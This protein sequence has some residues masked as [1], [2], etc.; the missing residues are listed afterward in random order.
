MESTASTIDVFISRKSADASLAKELYHFLIT[1]GLTVFDSDET[2][3]KMGNTDYLEAIDN[4]LVSCRHMIVVGSS[5]ENITSRW[6]KKEWSSF[7]NEKMSGR[8]NG[9]LL[10]VITSNLTIDNL[11]LS[12]RNNQVI[13]FDNA[14]FDRIAAYVGKDYRDPKY[15]PPRKGILKSKWLLP[16]ISVICLLTLFWYFINERNKPFDATLFLKPS[17]SLKLDPA[18]PPFEGGELTLL[19]DNKAEKKSISAEGEATFKQLP[20]SFRDKKVAASLTASYWTLQ[21]DTIALTKTVNLVLVPDQSLARIFGN[22]KDTKQ[23]GIGNCRITVDNN[24]T[25]FVTDMDGF[26]SITLPDKMQ[27]P[28]YIL[29]FNKEGFPEQKETYHPKSGT[30]DIELRK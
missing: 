8:K 3:P 29:H 19:L 28:Q 12:L 25:T 22:V 9:N 13:T 26:F 2:L 4:A 20:V 6:V 27:K 16:G 15:K 10:S 18:Y 23:N 11:P 30:I 7:V 14:N 1:K 17:P 24:D 21:Q 5:V